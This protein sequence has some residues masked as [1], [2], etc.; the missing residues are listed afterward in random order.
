MVEAL[1]VYQH[2]TIIQTESQILILRSRIYFQ[3]L[4]YLRNHFPKKKMLFH[5][6]HFFYETQHL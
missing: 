2:E 5:Q 4:R 6:K 1:K 3:I